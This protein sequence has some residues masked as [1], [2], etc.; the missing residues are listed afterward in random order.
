VVSHEDGCF[1]ELGQVSGSLAL[2]LPPRGSSAQGTAPPPHS[3]L[4]DCIHVG[5]EGTG[6]GSG[7]VASPGQGPGWWC[8]SQV[9]KNSPVLFYREDSLE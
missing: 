3:Q 9:V 7:R 5:G 8:G 2:H 4:T 1:L 6:T